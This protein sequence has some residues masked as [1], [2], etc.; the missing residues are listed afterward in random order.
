VAVGDAEARRAT[1]EAMKH[2]WYCSGCNVVAFLPWLSNQ[3]EG[4][5]QGLIVR[6]VECRCKVCELSRV[7]RR[8][9]E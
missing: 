7:F 6:E 2:L 4:L 5:G 1:G 3:D 9:T 8:V